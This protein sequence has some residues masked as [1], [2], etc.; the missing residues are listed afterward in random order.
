MITEYR[1]VAGNRTE[2]KDYIEN[3]SDFNMWA[4]TLNFDQQIKNIDKIGPICYLEL[5]EKETFKLNT[6]YVI[7]RNDKQ[8]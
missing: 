3:L 2:I 4:E 6:I 8:Q 5:K 7:L 1:L